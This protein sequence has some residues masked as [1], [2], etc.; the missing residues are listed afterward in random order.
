[1]CHDSSKMIFFFYFGAISNLGIVLL[2]E[3]NP[4]VWTA[5]IYFFLLH[6]TEY[7]GCKPWQLKSAPFFCSTG[8]CYDLFVWAKI[9]YPT[10]IHYHTARSPRA[11]ISTAG[12]R[13]TGGPS[14][15]AYPASVE[16]GL[17]KKLNM[18]PLN[19]IK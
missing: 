5:N 9:G 4:H 11:F 10:K 14:L 6:A 8:I 16:G 2:V 19:F 13:P 3:L 1:M 18:L 7:T 15:L 12:S 17:V